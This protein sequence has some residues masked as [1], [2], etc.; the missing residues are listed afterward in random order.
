MIIVLNVYWERHDD[1]SRAAGTIAGHIYS[2]PGFW[3]YQTER[4]EGLL[5]GEGRHEVAVA[6]TLED[7][8]GTIARSHEIVGPV[9]MT[10]CHPVRLQNTSV[11]QTCASSDALP[12]VGGP[13]VMW[14]IFLAIGAAAYEFLSVRPVEIL[15]STIA[16]L[17]SKAEE[18]KSVDLAKTEFLSVMNHEIR[19]PMNGILGM[20]ELLQDTRLTPDQKVF[21]ETIRSSGTSLLAIINDILDFS[22]VDAGHLRLADEEFDLGRI[23]DEVGRLLAPFAREKG[24]GLMI[25]V[26]P[27]LPLILRG[28]PSRLRQIVLN[29]TT[30]AIKFTPEGEVL[31][32]ISRDAQAA[33][34]GIGLRVSVRDTGVGLPDEALATIFDKFTQL[35]SSYSRSQEGT[36]LG[37][38]ISKALVE[39]MGGRIHAESKL[40]EGSVFWF[41]LNLGP[42][43]SAVRRADTALPHTGIVGRRVLLISDASTRQSILTE[44][45][46]AWGLVVKVQGYSS[47]IMA[48]P[49][50]ALEPEDWYD[51]LLIDDPGSANASSAETLRARAESSGLPVISI[52]S[53][54]H[55]PSDER[56]H[57]TPWSTVAKPVVAD[58]LL[59]EIVLSLRLEQS[60]DPQIHPVDSA[61][62][63]TTAVPT[64]A[65]G[66]PPVLVVDDSAT[67]R[68]LARAFLHKMG[69][70]AAMAKNGAEAVEYV[71]NSRPRMILMDVSMPQM[72]GLDATRAIRAWEDETCDRAFIVGLT[73]HAMPGDRDVCLEA[74]MEE[75]LS[76]P[77]RL[78]DFKHLLGKMEGP[79]S[80]PDPA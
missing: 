27:N 45:L 56:Q 76:K 43:G 9:A 31:L 4:L 42:A 16:N 74:G 10:V 53:L 32:D 80:T 23:A 15:D 7:D 54:R 71:R 46:E 3:Q 30:N 8:T 68:Q 50:Q 51:L 63:A 65:E 19:T 73:A 49:S 34:D 35:D 18:A 38:A 72:N 33:G 77:F 40:G 52:C 13:G 69:L 44:M 21:M 29:L 28:D 61:K 57:S 11:A 47:E 59:A 20:V 22:R 25:R 6:F 12:M 66:Q 14:L 79:E 70:E 55:F 36:G 67:S 1:A 37:L 62:K 41:A 17:K 60:R 5:E 48:G 26:D 78:V 75:Y 64:A 24:I 58:E 2:T 39:A